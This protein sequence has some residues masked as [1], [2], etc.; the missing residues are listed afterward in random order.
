MHDVLRHRRAADS[1]GQIH[2]RSHAP[3]ITITRMSPESNASTGTLPP[4]S[5]LLRSLS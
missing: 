2:E 3:A 4:H 5:C 1:I